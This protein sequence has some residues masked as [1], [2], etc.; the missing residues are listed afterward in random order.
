M[1]G[2]ADGLAVTGTPLVI[3]DDDSRGVAVAPTTVTVPEGGSSTYTVVLTSQPTGAVTVA[4]SVGGSSD[5]TVSPAA[6]TFATTA[7]STAQTVTV[8]AAADDDADADEATVAHTVSGADYASE[9][10]DDVAVMVTEDETPSTAVALTVAPSSVVENDGATSVTVTATLNEAPTT[11]ATTLTVSVSADTASTADFAA[12]ADF[13]LTIAAGRTSG[14]ATFML[15]PTGDGVDEENETLALGGTADGLTVTGTTLTIEDD[16]E[17]GIEVVPTT[18]GVDEGGSS[19]Y[20]VVLTSQPTGP[21]T[22]TPS[23]TGSTDVTVSPAGLTFA[24]AS[25][26][27]PQTMTVSAAQDDDAEADQATV[28]HAAS[29]ADYA[30]ETVDD[31]AVTVNEDERVS[32]AI[33]LSAVIGLLMVGA[34]GFRWRG[35]IWGQG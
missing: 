11:S 25:W 7:W 10:A 3:V 29:G 34:I 5:V 16:D 14:T 12:V 17:R 18:L 27:E 35:V 6:L 2:T 26:A 30:S 13:M 28:A 22:V 33:S 8:T 21:V 15:T 32:T 19:T 20:T 23:V 1:D 9:T 4:P 31:L 24:V